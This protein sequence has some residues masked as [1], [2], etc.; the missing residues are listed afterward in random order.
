MVLQHQERLDGSG[1]P[2]GLKV[3]NSDAQ[4]CYLVLIKPCQ[5]EDRSKSPII[6]EP[7]KRRLGK[8][9]ANVTSTIATVNL[10]CGIA[11]KLTNGSIGEVMLNINL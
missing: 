11:V 6:I 7:F 3:L 2:L 10:S 4:Y 1:Y 8:L 9:D 5:A